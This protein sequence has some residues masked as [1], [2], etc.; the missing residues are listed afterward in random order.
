M[1]VILVSKW[2]Q[3]CY[4]LYLFFHILMSLSLTDHQLQRYFYRPCL[5]WFPV[6]IHWRQHY[7]VN[8]EHTRTQPFYRPLSGT[9]WVIRYQK[10]HS[11]TYTFFAHQ[12]SFI[13]FLHLPRTIA[14]S[15]LS[16]HAWQSFRTTS[17]HVL[18]CSGA[19]CFRIHT[20]LH[21]IIILLSQLR[22]IPS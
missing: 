10:K 15:L 7:F 5:S 4:F 1:V 13:N 22:P 20:F 18:S 8:N 14:S 6:L 19:L 11:P 12:P 17:D 21:P 3:S 16:L 9:T 2:I